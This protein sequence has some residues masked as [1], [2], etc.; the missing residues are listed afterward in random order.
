M[1][2]ELWSICFPPIPT[3]PFPCP[4]VGNKGNDS[5][6][7]GPLGRDIQACWLF[8]SLEHLWGPPAV[9]LAFTRQ[10][11]NPSTELLWPQQKW[12]EKP[13]GTETMWPR[14]RSNWLLFEIEFS[15]TRV[16]TV[17]KALSHIISCISPLPPLNHGYWHY[18]SQFFLLFFPFSE[19]WSGLT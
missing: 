2:L 11:Y 12:L 7:I 1:Q 3:L 8:P 6:I 13:W 17:Y 18:S 10:W 15:P 9:L 16:Y 19:K 14:S 4:G 5:I